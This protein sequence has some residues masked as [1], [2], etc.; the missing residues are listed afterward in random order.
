[1]QISYESKK[2]II[3]DVPILAFPLSHSRSLWNQASWVCIIGQEN[4]VISQRHQVV[5][6]QICHIAIGQKQQVVIGQVRHIAIGQK[7]QV[8]IG[9]IRHI[10]IGQKQQ[11]IIGQVRHFAIGQKQQVIIGQIR[12][13]QQVI[14]GEEIRAMLPAQP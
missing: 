11:V 1:M 6:G 9:Q 5:I 2:C 3:C 13:K 10:A 8:T 12:H 14:I 4:Q 7:Q